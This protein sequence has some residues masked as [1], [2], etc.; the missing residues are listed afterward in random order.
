MKQTWDYNNKGFVDHSGYKIIIPKEEPKQETTLEEAAENYADHQLK[1]ISDKTS[2]FECVN[3]FIAGAKWQQERRY[4]EEDMKNAFLDG[5]Q[6]RDGYLPFTKAK[7][8]WFKEFKEF[9]NK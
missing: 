2:K 1:G 5:W 4:S 6:L 3:D 8:K 9:K 7:N